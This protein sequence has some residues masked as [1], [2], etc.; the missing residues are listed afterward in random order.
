MGK[1][2]FIIPEGAEFT[3]NYRHDWG[4]PQVEFQVSV[5]GRVIFGR[6]VEGYTCSSVKIGRDRKGCFISHPKISD[7]DTREHIRRCVTWFNREK[8]QWFNH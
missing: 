5:G 1:A 4:R 6:T 7:G 3:S 2:Y 8:G